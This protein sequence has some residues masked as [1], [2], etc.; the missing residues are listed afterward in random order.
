M[1][2]PISQN[3]SDFFGIVHPDISS[4][5]KGPDHA[6]KKTN[7][8][9]RAFHSALLHSLKKSH[10][11]ALVMFYS[12]YL[13]FVLSSLLFVLVFYYCS[14][15]ILVIVS[16]SINC[17]YLWLI[18]AIVIGAHLILFCQSLQ[19]I[20]FFFIGSSYSIACHQCCRLLS[21]VK[22]YYY[23]YYVERMTF[24]PSFL[25]PL[26][27]FLLFCFFFFFLYSVEVT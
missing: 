9:I 17:Y 23:H 15:C 18:L 7:E 2:R 4:L 16:Q 21:M 6:T 24:F 3:R 14:N 11:T 25:F 26:F 22:D 10:R 27:F 13:F 19:T 5:I 1:N 12:W 20:V 8:P